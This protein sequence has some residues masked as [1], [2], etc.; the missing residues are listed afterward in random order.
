MAKEGALGFSVGISSGGS[1][2]S[3][4]VGTVAV[5][6]IVGVNVNAGVEVNA[7][8]W[9]GSAVGEASGLG[10]SDGAG[11][12]VI[13]TIKGRP[14]GNWFGLQ[15]ASRATQPTNTNQG[16]FNASTRRN[17]RRRIVF[18]LRR[19]RFCKTIIPFYHQRSKLNIGGYYRATRRGGIQVGKLKVGG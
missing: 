16:H 18:E 5:M 11:E 7:G 8:V 2:V 9:L 17:R 15:A 10:V 6:V 1:N 3:V 19:S 12:L 4:G 13:V 14:S